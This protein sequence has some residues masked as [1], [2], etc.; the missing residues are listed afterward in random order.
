MIV[1]GTR[2]IAVVI[3]RGT[4]AALWINSA[5]KNLVVPIDNV[6]LW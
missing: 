3:L 1:K 5:T 2:K 6:A 4:L